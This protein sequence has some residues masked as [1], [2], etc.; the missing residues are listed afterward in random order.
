M[1]KFD[2][3]VIGAGPA[4]ISIAAEARTAGIPPERIIVLEKAEEHSFTLKK[5]Y[6]E[7]KLVTANYKGFEAVCTGV[8]CM[9]DLSKSETISFLDRS[10]SD[11]GIPVRYR[12]QVY[13]IFKHEERQ[14]FTVYTDRDTY[15]ATVV[16]IAIGILGKPNKPEYAI[17]RSLRGRLLFDVTTVPLRNI[18]ILVVGGGD[19]RRSTASIL[20]SRKIA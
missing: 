17:P 20:F 18:D 13:K 19:A 14:L 6:P 15:E 7:G 2:I 5:Y 10:L 9:P 3:V 1:S 12:E 11:H 8:M 4:G 16:A